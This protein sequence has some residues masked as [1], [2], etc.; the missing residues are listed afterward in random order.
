MLTI[1]ANNYA[2]L[3]QYIEK[4]IYDYVKNEKINNVECENKTIKFIFYMTNELKFNNFHQ[5]SSTTFSFVVHII[6]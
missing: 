3:R 5:N 1:F 4:L 6:E 2:L